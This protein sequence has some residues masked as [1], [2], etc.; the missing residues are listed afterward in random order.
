MRLNKYIAQ[1]GYCSRRKADQLIE[2]GVVTIN[3][4]PSEVGQKV[5]HNDVV[6]VNGQ[7]IEI[8]EKEVYLA[9]HKPFG[10]ICTADEKADNTIY[11]YLP[12]DQRLL[13]VGRLDV[14]S[15]GLLI[16]TSDGNVANAIAHG[17][18]S[19]EKEYIVTVDKPINRAFAKKMRDGVI[20]EGEKTKPALIKKMRD[21]RFSLII[22]QGRNRQVRKMCEAFGYKVKTLRR[23]RVMN[24][25][26]GAL[27]E[28][29]YRPLTK[30]ERRGLLASL[31]MKQA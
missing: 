21:D 28:G 22:T 16:M 14:E 9:F 2:D 29:N 17:S 26:L 7:K 1:S 30:N 5:A 11:D 15:S 25:K 31:G 8:N 6:A 23:V 18:G 27:G 13:Y 4:N 24:V 20:I 12:T 10:V 19:H 3:G